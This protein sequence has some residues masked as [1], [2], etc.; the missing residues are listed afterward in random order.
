MLI[1]LQHMHAS[2]PQMKR[3]FRGGGHFVM[4]LPVS[5]PRVWVFR[6]HE[7]RQATRG[8]TGHGA[9]HQLRSETS[10]SQRV[11][12]VQLVLAIGSAKRLY[13][14]PELD[15]SRK[16][17]RTD[18]AVIMKAQL[19]RVPGI[20]MFIHLQ[21]MHAGLPQMLQTV[22]NSGHFVIH[23]PVS[24]GAASE[25]VQTTRGP[26]GQRSS[27][28]R[29]ETTCRSLA[30]IYAQASAS[31]LSELQSAWIDRSSSPSQL[32]SV[33]ENLAELIPQY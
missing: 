8:P 17:N 12:Y 22:R 19:R 6:Q 25:R 2:L 24:T 16:L 33:K 30:C 18:P 1:H 28:L 20:T 26:T 4:Q 7:G 14:S 15:G 31:T 32:R 21:H 13:Q 3:T 29:S 9:S 11:H 23:F 10:E 5:K 27:Q